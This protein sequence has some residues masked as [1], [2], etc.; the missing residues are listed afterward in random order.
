M[1][2]KIYQLCKYSE[3]YSTSESKGF[4]LE[5]LQ[6]YLTTFYYRIEDED[7]PLSYTSWLYED[8]NVAQIAA[9]QLSTTKESLNAMEHCHNVTF[10]Y[11]WVVPAYLSC[12][13]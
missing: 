8:E 1:T 2:K 11:F 4:T 13:E 9:V 12:N 6:K 7:L 10:D 3:R 5:R